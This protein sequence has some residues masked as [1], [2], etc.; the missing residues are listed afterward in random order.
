MDRRR[1]GGIGY[2]ELSLVGIDFV[3]FYD[4]Y[5]VSLNSNMA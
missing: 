5:M 2:I 3:W 1:I 4:L